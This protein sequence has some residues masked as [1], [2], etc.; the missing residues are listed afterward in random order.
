[1][2]L[3][4]DVRKHGYCCYILLKGINNNEIIIMI[5]SQ[6]CVY[7]WMHTYVCVCM[8][9]CVYVCCVCLCSVSVFSLNKP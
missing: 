4:S 9:G 1:M 6:R 2:Q 5:T 8:C 7:A 3:L